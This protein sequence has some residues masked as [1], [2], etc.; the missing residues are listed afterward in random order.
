MVIIIIMKYI[1]SGGMVEVTRICNEY[2]IIVFRLEHLNTI[3]QQL[4]D[5]NTSISID[6]DSHGEL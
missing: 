6:R 3:V 5:V 1:I 4:T 2:Y